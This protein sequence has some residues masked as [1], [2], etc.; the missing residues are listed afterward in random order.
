[1][2]AEIFLRLRNQD[3]RI[4]P[5][6]I[7]YA[8]FLFFSYFHVFCKRWPIS[9]N[10]TR[11]HISTKVFLHQKGLLMTKQ[12]SVGGAA[13]YFTGLN[14]CARLSRA[15]MLGHEQRGSPS[16]C[17]SRWCGY[18][19]LRQ[20][21]TYT[22]EQKHGGHSMIFHDSMYHNMRIHV[23]FLAPYFLPCPSFIRPLTICHY[24]S[25][26]K[27]ILRAMKIGTRRK[28]SDRARV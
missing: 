6:K 23:I 8:Y 10:F 2:H 24:Y 15:R 3:N 22:V 20:Y 21:F 25:Q 5:Q 27:Q 12:P 17:Y 14:L 11:R 18:V 16:V 19:I 26:T 1:M 7:L 28:E 4:G 13:I 9:L